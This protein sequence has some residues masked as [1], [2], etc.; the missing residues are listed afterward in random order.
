MTSDNALLKVAGIALIVCSL[1]FVAVFTYL[2][3]AFG[4]PDV[5]DRGAAEVLPRL[6]AGGPRLRTVWFLYAALPLGIL[7]AGATT[8][9]VLE[10]GG[11][12][13]RALGV[14]AAVAASLAMMIGLLRWPTIEWTLARYWET[15]PTASRTTLSAIFDAS[16]LFLGN[17]IGEFIGEMC[18]ALWFVALGIAF[19]RDERNKL[20]ALGMGAGI[21]V[22]VAGLRN[23]TSAVTLFAQINNITLPLWLLTL[24]VVFFRDRGTRH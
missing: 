17:V 13:L 23:I 2:A 6:A 9:P 1:A 11:K 22:A 7:F 8:A 16:N 12:A 10:R 21:L 24:G 15:A 20:G 14:G 3:A 19:W 5:L 18:T 4:Y